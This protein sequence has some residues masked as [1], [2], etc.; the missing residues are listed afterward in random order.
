MAC[1]I[2]DICHIN[3]R[4]LNANKLDAL[5]ADIASE[6]DIICLTETHLPNNTADLKLPGFQNIMCKN[7]VGRIGGGVGWRKIYSQGH[8]F[9]LLRGGYGLGAS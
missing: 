4:S 5:K 1:N 7:R 3:V 2:L 6:F 8:N 9:S